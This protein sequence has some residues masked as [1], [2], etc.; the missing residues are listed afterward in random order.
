LA[1]APASALRIEQLPAPVSAAVGARPVEV[2]AS[3]ALVRFDP[4]SNTAARSSALAAAGARLLSELGRGGW[5]LAALPPGLSVPAGLALLRGAPGILDA[6]P[7]YVHRPVRRPNDPQV[8]SQ[9]HLSNINAFAGWDFE[10]GTSSRVTI[11]VIDSGIQGSH[12][13]LSSKLVGTSQFFDPDFPFAQSANQPPT[14]A[15]NH[16]T[17][18]AG[19][20]AAATDNASEVA[21]LSWGANLL[22]LK[23]FNDN[24]C[25]PAGDCAAG[26]GSTDAAIIAALNYAATLEDTPTYGKIVVNMSLGSLFPSSCPGPM[27]TAVTNAVNAGVV[28]VAAAGNAGPYDNSMDEPGSCAGLI[29]VGATD[30]GDNIASFSSR[31]PELAAGG[32]V[33]PGVNIVT[34]NVGGGTVGN[35]SGTSFATPMVAGVAALIRSAKPAFTPAQVQSTLRASADSVSATSIAT[36]G[37][38]GT[39]GNTTGA[40]RL[41]AF[42]AL[43]LAIN[44]TL[45]GYAGDQQAIAFPNPFR[46]GQH[47]AVTVTVPTGLQGSPAQIRIYAMDGAFVRE[48]TGQTWDGRNAAG[49]DVASGTYIFVV[50]TEAGTARG[51]IG[52]LR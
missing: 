39:L 26:C 22:S 2:A 18:V 34:T 27:Q 28:V 43:R 21:G 48:L 29:P 40:G 52:L 23:V 1:A 13:E 15:C 25:N 8:G 41:D 9:W 19:I 31:G 42:R 24:D 37:G 47:G 32:L 30:A 36:T 35:A 11:A 6:A 7:N 20:A 46:P 12:P 38:V 16:A 5:V 33:A 17:Q 3:E 4:S 49:R 44:G 45:S 51:R 50:K 14:P 10:V